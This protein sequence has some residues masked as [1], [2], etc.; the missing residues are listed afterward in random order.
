[1]IYESLLKH[2]SSPA[3][4]Q[5]QLDMFAEVAEGIYG[6]EPRTPET[7]SPI[8]LRQWAETVMIPILRKQEAVN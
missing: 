3:F 6:A 7:T 2:G 5:S 4:A 1:M 8:T